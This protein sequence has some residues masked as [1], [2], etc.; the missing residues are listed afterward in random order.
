M[1]RIMAFQGLVAAIV[2]EIKKCKFE[3]NESNKFK[4]FVI[5]RGDFS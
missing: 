5:H 1:N 4:R 3:L 2:G